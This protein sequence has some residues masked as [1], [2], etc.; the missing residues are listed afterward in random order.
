LVTDGGAG[1]FHAGLLVIS[2]G[3]HAGV[4]RSGGT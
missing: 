3:V 1:I 4:T 2:L